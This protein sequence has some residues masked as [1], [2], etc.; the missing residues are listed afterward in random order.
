MPFTC[1]VKK[2]QTKSFKPIN[3]EAA[4][5]L[6][7][8]RLKELRRK[9]DISQLNLAVEKDINLR[10]LSA[11]ET[12]SDIRLTSIIRL[13]NALGISLKEFFSEGFD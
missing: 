1:T 5:K 13:C 3:E 8:K 11:W 2:Q 7:G 4:L 9:A 6:F 12:G 10:R